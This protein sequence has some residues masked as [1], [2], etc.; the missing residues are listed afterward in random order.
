MDSTCIKQTICK[1][2]NIFQHG[3][4]LVA[5]FLN[6][7]NMYGDLEIYLVFVS[8]RKKVIWLGVSGSTLN[9]MSWA[10]KGYTSTSEIKNFDFRVKPKVLNDEKR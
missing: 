8:A 7:I 10:C 6:V 2:L 9:L 1:V 4:T 3:N 5:Y